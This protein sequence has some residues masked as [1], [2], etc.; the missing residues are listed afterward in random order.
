[1][2]LRQG[3]LQS[4][5]TI[6]N[7][8][9]MHAR[10]SAEPPDAAVVILVHGVVVSSSYMMPT[11]ELLAPNY[12]V[13]AP[14]LP[15][16]GKS[17]KPK[18]TLELSELADSLCKWMDAVGIQ[19]ATMLGNSFGC[20]II[21]EFAVRYGDRI[22]RAIL[23][24]PTIDR[25]ART[26]PQQMWRLL[27]NSPL[28]DP[29]QAPLQAYDYW[30]AGWPRLVRTVQIALA[31]RIE[32]KLPYMHVPTLVVRGKEDPVVPQQW[33]E[34]VVHLLPNARL[35]V[36]PGGGH[37]LNYSRPLELTRVTRA[38]IEAKDLQTK[39]HEIT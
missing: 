30:V 33:A 5:Y 37:T 9:L 34:E 10:V 18:H 4:Q 8:L 17:D 6:V 26:L 29:S 19:R 28:E 38:F 13:Y 32:E 16:Y 21:V 39:K 11:A 12:R 14:D 36:I 3:R 31:D 15:G 24:G 7:G 25:H 1:M 23:Q 20:Q 27:L 35:A 2:S 22:E